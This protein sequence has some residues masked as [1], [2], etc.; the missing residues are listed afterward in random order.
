MRKGE[1]FK[2]FFV[3]WYVFLFHLVESA[4]NEFMLKKAHR[5]VEQ[6]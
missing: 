1:T 4:N 6:M 2:T 3:Y 5:Q